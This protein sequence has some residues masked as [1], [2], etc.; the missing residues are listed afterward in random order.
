M[1]MNF[2]VMMVRV[3]KERYQQHKKRT[4][5]PLKHISLIEYISLANA[6]KEE[7]MFFSLFHRNYR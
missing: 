6:H 7:A 1:K 5:R 2:Q 4:C 3:K